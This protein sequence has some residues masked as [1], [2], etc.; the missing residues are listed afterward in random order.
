MKTEFPINTVPLNLKRTSLPSYQQSASQL[1]LKLDRISTDRY[2]P[3]RRFAEFHQMKRAGPV[4]GHPVRPHFTHPPVRGLQFSSP[5]SPFNRLGLE[6]LA[7][8]C[9][10]LKLRSDGVP[11]RRHPREC[12]HSIKKKSGDESLTDPST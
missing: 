5:H 12:G 1:S 7:N 4:D 9:P 6:R 3:L 8:R 2:A 11:D 10:P